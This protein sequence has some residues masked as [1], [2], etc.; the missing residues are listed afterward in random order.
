MRTFVTQSFA[1][2]AIWAFLSVAFALP[3]WMAMV[4]LAVAMGINSLSLLP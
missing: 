1:M 3:L 2:L 4:F